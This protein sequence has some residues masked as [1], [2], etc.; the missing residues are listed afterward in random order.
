MLQIGLVKHSLRYC[1]F[2]KQTLS[3]DYWSERKLLQVA[4][5]LYVMFT[6]ASAVELYLSVVRLSTANPN[7]DEPWNLALP[8]SQLAVAESCRDVAASQKISRH[9]V[10]V[11][12]CKW[13]LLIAFY[14]TLYVATPI[15]A[16]VRPLSRF[17]HVMAQATRSHPRAC[18]FRLEQLK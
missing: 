5:D 2:D 6:R 11:S 4:I 7:I 14:V 3:D 9:S 16:E 17:L 13:N 10:E 1:D 15:H 8:L 12:I 18:L